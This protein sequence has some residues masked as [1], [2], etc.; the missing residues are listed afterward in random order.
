MKTRRKSAVWTMCVALAAPLLI[1][2]CGRGHSHSDSPPPPATTSPPPPATA[3]VPASASES[4]EGFIGYLQELV[5]SS[6]DTLEPV[7]TSTLTAPTDETSEPL[8]VN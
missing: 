6:A 8:Q 5:V 4:I 7:D 1:S 3:Q 2:A